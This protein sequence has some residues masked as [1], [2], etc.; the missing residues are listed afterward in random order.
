MDRFRRHP[1]RVVTCLG[2]MAL[3]CG[4]VAAGF[5]PPAKASPSGWNIVVGGPGNPANAPPNAILLGDTC[6]DAWSCWAVGV[7]ESG[8]GNPASTLGGFDQRRGPAPILENSNTQ[9]SLPPTV[10]KRPLPTTQPE[11]FAEYWNGSIWS[12]VPVAEPS[13]TADSLLYATTC[14][15]QTDCWAVGGEDLGAAGQT[16]APPVAIAQGPVAAACKAAVCNAPSQSGAAGLVEHWNG[17][18]W[19]LTGLP[20]TSGYLTSVTCPTADDCWAVGSTL[21]QSGDPLNSY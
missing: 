9:A 6:A 4:V 10:Q 20:T 1:L 7:S 16:A 5:V 13:N 14:L 21:D 3:V 2:A 18:A 15:T 11:A 17:T 19:S 8:S 12:T